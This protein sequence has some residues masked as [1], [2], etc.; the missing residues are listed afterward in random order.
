MSKKNIPTELPSAASVSASV[1]DTIIPDAQPLLPVSKGENGKS[2]GSALATPFD[3][4]K[5][6]EKGQA[7]EAYG[8]GVWHTNKKVVGVWTIAQTR[9]AWVNL[10]DLGW[11]KLYSGSDSSIVAFNILTTHALE[12]QTFVNVL[13]ENDQIIEMYAW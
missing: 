10:T 7:E 9:N 1:S 11:K 12:K 2:G 5:E 8:A 13:I 4:I 3:S 6:F